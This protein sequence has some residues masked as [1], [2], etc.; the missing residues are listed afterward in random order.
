[1]LPATCITVL[2][3]EKCRKQDD[4]RTLVWLLW[5]WILETVGRRYYNLGMPRERKRPSK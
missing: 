5:T 2:A 1:M 3:G 4:G